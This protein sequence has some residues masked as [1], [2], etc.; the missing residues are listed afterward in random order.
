MGFIA[1]IVL[2]GIAGWIASMIMKTDAQQGLLAN[3]VV[4]IIGAFV[5]GF[6]FSLFGG[7][8]VSGFNVPSLVVAVIG[9]VITLYIYKMIRR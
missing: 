1:W 4:G 7:S 6:V 8:G 3:I 5:G 9:A 2:G